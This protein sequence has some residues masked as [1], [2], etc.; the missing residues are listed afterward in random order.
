[1]L[2]TA[3]MELESSR[4]L[5]MAFGPHLVE[6]QAEWR[7]VPVVVRSTFLLLAEELRHLR[8]LLVANPAQDHQPCP[9]NS[10]S[11]CIDPR[12]EDLQDQLSQLRLQVQDAQQQVDDRHCR[13][14]AK[15]SSL[16]GEVAATAKAAADAQTQNVAATD[17]MT[18]SWTAE[19]EILKTRMEQQDKRLKK[20]KR[21]RTQ[22]QQVDLALHELQKSQELCSQELRRLQKV[23]EAHGHRVA[24]T[25]VQQFEKQDEEVRAAEH[26]K[27]GEDRTKERLK[28]HDGAVHVLLHQRY[29]EALKRLRQQERGSGE[30]WTTPDKPKTM[31]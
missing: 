29:V 3:N 8:L 18:V 2:I 30:H 23:F 21:N 15:F 14:K 22:D 24:G 27:S 1:M 17:R 16:W 7:D 9:I 6:G 4:L 10:Q 20:D 28:K 19:L 12:I 5:Q 13:T 26:L 31:S 25:T 11:A